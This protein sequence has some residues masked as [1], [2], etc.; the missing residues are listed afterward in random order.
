MHNMH[1]G[2]TRLTRCARPRRYP[3][4]HLLMDTE[5]RTR[6]RDNPEKTGGRLAAAPSRV[7]S[8][9]AARLPAKSMSGRRRAAGLYHTHQPRGMSRRSEL[10][11]FA[12]LLHHPHDR[13]APRR[14]VC[15]VC[16]QRCRLPPRLSSMRS[17]NVVAAHGT[18]HRSEASSHTACI[19]QPSSPRSRMRRLGL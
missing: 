11:S 2:D 3:N 13:S 8:G 5:K 7:Q 6:A 15:G 12:P 9:L 10:T 16:A 18:R 14:S 4:S 19:G 17:Q 1:T